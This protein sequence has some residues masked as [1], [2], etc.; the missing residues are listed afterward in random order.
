MSKYNKTVLTQAGLDLAKRA[1]AGQAKFKVTRAVTSADDLGNTPVQQLERMTEIPNIMQEGKILDAEEV[2][3]DNAVIGV[4]LRFTNEGLTNGYKIRIIGLYV[5]EDGQTNDF[6]YAVSTAVEPEYMPDYNDNVLYRFN[7][8]LYLVIGRAQNVTVV[9]DDDTVVSIKKFN[10]FKKQMEDALKIKAD[11]SSLDNFYTKK[12]VNDRIEQAGKVKKIRINEGEIVEPDDQGVLNLFVDGDRIQDFP[13]GVTDFNN[14]TQTGL[15]RMP[16][17]VMT[18]ANKPVNDIQVLRNAFLKV[19]NDAGKT[20]EILQIFVSGFGGQIYVRSHFAQ[21]EVWTA[22]TKITPSNTLSNDDITNMI[23]SKVDGLNVGQFV[24]KVNGL[25]PDSDG[26]VNVTLTVARGFDVNANA[27][28]KMTEENLHGSNQILMDQMAGQDI[29]NWAKGQFQAIQN[30]STKRDLTDADDVNNVTE[31]GRYQTLDKKPKNV[32]NDSTGIWSQLLVLKKDP[33][34]IQQFWIQEDKVWIRVISAT[35]GPK[36]EWSSFIKTNFFDVDA[37]IYRKTNAHKTWSDVLGAL[38]F[39]DANV[40]VSLRDDVQDDNGLMVGGNSAGIAFGGYDTKG[41][42][43]VKWNDHKARITGGN[44]DT[45]WSEDVAWKSD[46]NNL[47]NQVNDLINQINYIKQ[48]YLQGKRFP[49]NQE[50]QVE[51]WENSNP[52]GIAIIEK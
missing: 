19:I 50:A 8:Q 30:F 22:W 49:V 52:N 38:N 25:S 33:E 46:V 1:N 24:K 31:T 32:P 3:S 37:P 28:T 9:V 27:T 13:A 36:N 39:K 41:I 42:L 18:I 12:E 20:N 40:L 4:S 43:S 47:Q 16:Q 45:V 10:D 14:L 17:N 34:Q 15:Y 51:Q 48:N 5:Q 11:L 26:N 7:T 23:N 29:V 44:S 2:E 21:N 6:L 35:Q